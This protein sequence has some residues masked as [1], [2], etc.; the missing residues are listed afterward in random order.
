MHPGSGPSDRDNDVLFPP[1][2]AA[3]LGTGV[4]VCSF[5]KRGV[6][7]SS[8]SWLLAGIRDQAADLALSLRAAR[9]IVADGPVGLFGHSQGGWVVLEAARPVGADF[10]ITNS[11][12]A[13]S[14]RVQEAFST[15]NRL[16]DLGWAENRVHDACAVFDQLLGL[17]AEGRPFATAQEWMHQRSAIIAELQAAGAFVPDSDELWSFAAS[18]IE[19]DPEPALRQLTAPLLAVLGGS[20]PVVPV[21]HSAAVYRACVPAELLELEIVAG[22]DHRLHA[23]DS[24]AFVPGYLATLESFVSAR[25]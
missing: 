10:V 24:D 21:E 20:D 13:V 14:P 18:I 5:D 7:E 16:R 2:R 17:L 19:H 25:L 12:P 23:P 4:A 22:G 9:A 15:A 1:I 11:G 3:F 8:G 6:G